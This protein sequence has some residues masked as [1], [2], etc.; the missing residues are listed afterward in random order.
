LPQW[1]PKDAAEQ[2]QAAF[3]NAMHEVSARWNERY[4]PR[5]RQL[6]EGA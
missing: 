2:T 5:L 4:I 6:V 3:E 1:F